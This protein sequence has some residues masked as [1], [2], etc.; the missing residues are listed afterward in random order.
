MG[1]IEV[2]SRREIGSREGYSLGDETGVS[3]ER[4]GSAVASRF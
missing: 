3:I 2:E 1:N 4:Y